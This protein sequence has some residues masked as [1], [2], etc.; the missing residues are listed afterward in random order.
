MKIVFFTRIGSII[1]EKNAQNAV[2]KNIYISETTI[3]KQIL[4][5]PLTSIGK[6][7]YKT[8]RK[9]VT[10]AF[11]FPVNFWMKVRNFAKL[12]CLIDPLKTK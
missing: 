2:L 5:T 11:P 1:I 9:R 7:A 12:E 6:R 4:S 10:G 3:D 8:N